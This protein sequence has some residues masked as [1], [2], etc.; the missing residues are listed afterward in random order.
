MSDGR[1][2][3][4][5]GGSPPGAYPHSGR[6]RT[7]ATERIGKRLG[8]ATPEEIAQVIEGLNEILGA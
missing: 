8:V 3:K 2:R 4:R 6:V 5:A 1:S 7:R